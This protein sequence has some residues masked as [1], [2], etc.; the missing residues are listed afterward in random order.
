MD[1]IATSCITF[2][3]DPLRFGDLSFEVKA[4]YP[5]LTICIACCCISFLDEAS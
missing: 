3:F 1:C 4:S 5:V 2:L